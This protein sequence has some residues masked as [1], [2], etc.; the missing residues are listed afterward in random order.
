MTETIE[1]KVSKDTSSP[2]HRRRAGGDDRVAEPAAGPRVS[3][4]LHRCYVVKVRDGQV[5]NRPVYVAI[6]VTCNGERDILGLWMGDGGE[7][8]KFWLQFL[9]EL[10]NRGV[11]DCCIVVCDCEDERVPLGVV[12]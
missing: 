10:R 4:D 12:A 8:A 3:G 1:P 7:G 11:A 9:T 2:D 6:G 5:T